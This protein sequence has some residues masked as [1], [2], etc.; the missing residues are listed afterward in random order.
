MLLGIHHSQRLILHDTQ[1]VFDALPLCPAGLVAHQCPHLHPV[2]PL[3]DW[4]PH[5]ATH[6][7]PTA[8]GLSPQAEDIR[9]AGIDLAGRR[10]ARHALTR[11][12]GLIVK[13][14]RLQIIHK[15]VTA[16]AALLVELYPAAG[17]GAEFPS[18][19]PG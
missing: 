9:V 3:P 18:A 17:G 10:T 6:P 5:T 1:A 16:G 4:R 19:A 13:P 15:L 11:L 14:K 12:L 2:Q 7:P 8:P